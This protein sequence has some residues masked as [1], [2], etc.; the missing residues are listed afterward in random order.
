MASIMPHKLLGVRLVRNEA[1]DCNSVLVLQSDA[2]ATAYDVTRNE[3]EK[4]AQVLRELAAQ[5]SDPNDW[6][7]GI[8]TMQDTFYFNESVT[9]PPDG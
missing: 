3:L 5:M 9:Q 8:P 6:G 7:A 2:G 4:L 1:D